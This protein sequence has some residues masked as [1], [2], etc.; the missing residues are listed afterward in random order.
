MDSIDQPVVYLHRQVNPQPPAFLVVFTPGQPG[1]RVVPVKI[2][3]V[4]QG[5]EV[6]PGSTGKINQL[7]GL[8]CLIQKGGLAGG[9]FSGVGAESPGV[10]LPGQGDDLEYFLPGAH[11]GKTGV[12]PVQQNQILPTDAEP[13]GRQ[14]VQGFGAGPDQQVIEGEPL[15]PG[16]GPDVGDVQG[17]GYGIEGVIDSGEKFVDL[18]PGPGFFVEDLHGAA[19]FGWIVAPSIP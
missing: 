11:A 3:L 16:K 1:N 2:V 18:F 13:K 15:C 10:G 14:A 6:E 17:Q 19:S 5:R 4:G 7:V 9:F 8:R 12:R